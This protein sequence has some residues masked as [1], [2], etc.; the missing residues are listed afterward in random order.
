[1]GSTYEIQSMLQEFEQ[2]MGMGLVEALIS[3]IPSML[4]SLAVY[5]FTALSLYTIAARRGIK[6][7]WLA[8]IPYANVWL[9]GC[10]ADQYR[11]VARGQTKYRRR[12]LLFTEIAGVVIGVLVVVLLIVMLVNMSALFIYAI[13]S[14]CV[15]FKLIRGTRQYDN[16]LL[17]NTNT[18]M[19]L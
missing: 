4:I 5:V 12:V 10:I 11:A 3:E 15:I 7:P 6:N 17:M 18:I 19:R 2:A 8:W 13:A 14:K 16:I 9:L 1:M